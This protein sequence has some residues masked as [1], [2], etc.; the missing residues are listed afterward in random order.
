MPAGRPLEPAGN[1]RPR[2]MTAHR[3]AARRPRTE[4]G[5]QADS[6]VV[7]PAAEGISDAPR[8]LFDGRLARRLHRR[9]G[10]RVRLNAAR[11]GGLPLRHRPDPRG[12]RPPA[13]PRHFPLEGRPPPLPRAAS[14]TS[15][16]ESSRPAMSLPR[17]GS[18]PR[19]TTG[20]AGE[21][22]VE[23]TT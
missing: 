3:E 22:D 4:P 18:L 19:D 8:D 20:T 21:D 13:G 5:V 14:A 2:W 11:R 23:K 1:G 15:R 6:S 7:R 17:Y 16:P 10:G 12:R 9:A